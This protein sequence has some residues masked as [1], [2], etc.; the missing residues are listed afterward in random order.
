[1]KKICLLSLILALMPFSVMATINVPGDQPTIQAGINAAVDGD[2]VLIADGTYTGTGNYNIEFKGK[3]ITVKSA[4]GPD[5]CIIDC[6]QLGRGFIYLNTRLQQPSIIDG[7]TIMN[8]DAKGGH[9]GGVYC[10]VASPDIKR[11][12]FDYNNASYGGGLNVKNIYGSATVTD[13]LFTNNTAILVV[14]YPLTMVP[15]LQL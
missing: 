3:V 5:N 15:F 8:G 6:Q 9:G 13:C 10:D 1:M 12:V 7:L 11:C 4:N 2:I 14:V